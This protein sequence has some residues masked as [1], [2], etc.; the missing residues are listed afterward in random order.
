MSPT[1]PLADSYSEAVGVWYPFLLSSHLPE[2][3]TLVGF[4]GPIS[5]KSFLGEGG[6]ACI[7]SVK[8]GTCWELPVQW[9]TL[10]VLVPHIFHPH[11]P[12]TSCAVSC[13]QSLLGDY[14]YSLPHSSYLS[15]TKLSWWICSQK[16]HSDL[17]SAIIVKL[18]K[19]EWKLLLLIEMTT[20][21]PV[22]QLI[23]LSTPLWK[24]AVFC[25]LH[26]KGAAQGS[27]LPE[28]CHALS[29]A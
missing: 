22:S 28:Q 5:H 21:L 23:I 2:F 1:L 6:V 27:L 19:A 8:L 18:C 14:A 29:C 12:W 25:L 26:L 10:N 4:T 9:A 3:F 20:V 17:A 16:E 11:A 15:G 24:L 7:G 13:F